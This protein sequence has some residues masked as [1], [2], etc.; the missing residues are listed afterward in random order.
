MEWKYTEQY[1]D[2]QLSPARP[3]ARE[4][5]YAA[6]WEASDGPIETQLISYEVMFTEPFYQLM[7]QQLLARELERRRELGAE[8]VRVVHVSPKGNEAYQASLPS[9]VPPELGTT[10]SEVW[11]R[12][13]R[14]PSRFVS[15]D[16]ARFAQP[17]ISSEEYVTRYG[18]S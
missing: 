15:V 4:Q 9:N 7:R 17:H 10:V 6:A 13:L 5:R 11:Q 1:L 2:H 12:L 3:G 14:D 16:S 18:H 8:A